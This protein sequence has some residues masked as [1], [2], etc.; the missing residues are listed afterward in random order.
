M[1]SLNNQ[2]E[3]HLLSNFI[4]TFMSK[5]DFQKYNHSKQD[6]QLV[7]EYK[8]YLLNDCLDND[9]YIILFLIIDF[10]FTFCKNWKNE[11]VVYYFN[12]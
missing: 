1:L 10:R 3:I 8:T 11:R 5:V 7:T 6:F 4:H 9:D 2:I 12:R